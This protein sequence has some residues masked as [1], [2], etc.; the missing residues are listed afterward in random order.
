MTY[1]GTPEFESRRPALKAA[2]EQSR[3]E[4]EARLTLVEAET[5]PAADVMS[6]EEFATR[7][8]LGDVPKE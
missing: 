5:A 7:L 6:P 8:V 2:F 4:F 1:V 3:Q